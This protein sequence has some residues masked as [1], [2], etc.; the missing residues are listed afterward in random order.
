M[1]Q[2]YRAFLFVFCFVG[3]AV[4][5]GTVEPVRAQVITNPNQ[6]TG[7]YEITNADPEILEL[8]DF[9][10]LSVRADSIDHDPVLR[11]TLQNGVGVSPTARS[12]ELTVEA[13]EPGAGIAYQLRFT[14]VQVGSSI[15]NGPRPITEPVEPAPAQVEPI[16][17]QECLGL[18]RVSTVDQDSGEPVR[19]HELRA[20]AYP[21]RETGFRTQRA[22]NSVR[23]TDALGLLFPEDGIPVEIDIRVWYRNDPSLDLILL[24]QTFEIA[25]P[26]CDQIFELTMEVPED[27]RPPLVFGT[28][29]GSFDIVGEEVHQVRLDTTR[30]R[31]YYA[32]FPTVFEDDEMPVGDQRVYFRN[33][34]SG[35][36]Y[37]YQSSRTPTRFEVPIVA[38]ETTDLGDTF[39]MIPGRLQAD[40]HLVGPPDAISGSGLSC[41]ADLHRDIDQDDDGDDIPDSL[42]F[43]FGSY[44]S[45][46]GSAAMAPGASRAAS[47]AYGFR[48]FSGDYE[49]VLAE[50]RGAVDLALTHLN[51]ENA[52]WQRPWV[53][54]RFVDVDPSDPEG[55][56]DSWANWRDRLQDE[57]LTRAG[58]ISQLR[59]QRVCFSEVRMHFRSLSGSFYD[60]RLTGPG[61]FEGTDFSGLAAS[62]E[63]TNISAYGT[64]T[65]KPT[66][67]DQGLVR[68]CL[69]Q[70]SYELTPTIQ[71]VNPDGT[72]SNQT[73]QA[74]NLEV[75]CRQVLDFRS[76]LQV[77]LDHVPRCVPDPSL[78]LTGAIH[79]TF[80]IESIVAEVDGAPVTGCGAD[81]GENPSYA[82]PVLLNPCTNS[83]SVTATD[84]EGGAASAATT[85]SV[86]TA[87]PTL[88]ACPDV[89][90][91][92]TDENGAV[93]SFGLGATDACDGNVPVICDFPSGSLF[94]VGQTLVSCQAFDSCSFADACSFRVTVLPADGEVEPDPENTVCTDETFDGSELDVPWQLGSVG[95]GDSGAAS[96]SGG[97][98]RLTGT[99][100]SLYHGPEDH[101]VFLWREAEPGDFRAELE[102]VAPSVPAAGG[103]YRKATLMVRSGP[104]ADA[105]RIAV[106]YV[107]GFPGGAA[108]M[109]DVRFADG[110]AQELGSTVPGVELPVRLAVERRGTAWTVY[111]AQEGQPWVRPAGAQGGSVD[112]DLGESPR[113]G[114]MVTSYDL[115][116]PVT[117]D[118]GEFSL[119]KPNPHMPGTT[120]TCNVAE[121]R[122]VLFLLDQSGSLARELSDGVTQG[123]ATRWILQDAVR[124]IHGNGDHRLALVSASADPVSFT[125]PLIE[126]STVEDFTTDGSA[127]ESALLMLADPDPESPTP[128]AHG[129]RAAKQLLDDRADTGR[130]PVLVWV[131]DGLSTIDGDG[132]GPVFYPEAEVRALDLRLQDGSYLSRGEMAWSGDFNPILGT[133][134][135]EVTADVMAELEALQRDYPD[136]RVLTLHTGTAS[137]PGYAQL[138]QYGMLSLDELSSLS[139]VVTRAGRH[140][141]LRQGPEQLDIPVDAVGADALFDAFARL[142]GLNSARLLTALESL[143]PGEITLWSNDTRPALTPE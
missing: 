86:D 22:V 65:T 68:M 53:R 63:I 14:H 83:L 5:W 59:D 10:R 121:Q 17:I 108:V 97:V 95:D 107:P 76:D 103:E 39:V 34:F 74:L 111:M 16:H 138:G 9:T 44:L 115:T 84:S 31:N 73:L 51:N 62:Y 99:G 128:L 2:M 77:A 4:V 33:I 67:S 45:I 101:G 13:G 46:G 43:A 98:L 80:G 11:S 142:P 26:Y 143:E 54:Y 7:L 19:V 82:I 93:V 135:G 89:E 90:A 24:E 137:D 27:T 136:L 129:L 72:V 105:P 131:T 110:S 66:A 102:V 133:F 56:I 41:L 25:G 96:L 140:W 12:F 94:P 85:S 124:A 117:F 57:T 112:L 127:V 42:N 52:L 75:G 126:V 120:G 109:F 91:Q 69:P 18:V 100:S 88:G 113:V 47:G 122:D 3:L 37:E 49:P 81:C 139:L 6:I 1:G 118:F 61:D 60:P 35:R 78:T 8:V 141:R 106:S 36:G 132:N 28:V 114:P 104:D 48:A 23:N 87:P 123:Q 92:A 38:N 21:Q 15:T 116:T 29:T 119:C 32:P 55:Y 130:T 30:G 134:M 40:F 64:P 58:E 20:H 79:G 71:A 125:Q 50:H 70:G